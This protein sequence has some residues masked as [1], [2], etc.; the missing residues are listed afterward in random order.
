MTTGDGPVLF[1]LC[2]LQSA[3]HRHRGIARYATEQA[4]AVA[5]LFPGRLGACL[6]NPDLT[7][8][9]RLDDLLATLP[10]HTSEG[11]DWA[12]AGLL[13]IASP[14]EMS[15]PLHRLLPPAAR[16]AK[17]PWVVTFYDLIPLLMPEY[18]LEDP[19][20]R[21]RYRARVQLVRAADAVLTLSEAT[22]RD[23]VEHLGLDPERVTV[24]G[25]GTGPE[26]VPPAS[27]PAAAATAAAAVPGLRPP[28]VFYTGS[29][30]KRKNLERL[31][32]A[33]AS[34]PPG[35]RQAHQLVVTCALG[36]LQRNH[37]LWLAGKAG[38]GDDLLLTGFVPDDVLLRLYQ[39]TELFIFPSLYEGYGLP[40]AEALACG[41]PVLAAG[42]SSMPEIVGPESLF[43]PED[44][45]SMATAI[46]RGLTDGGLRDR[47]LGAAGKPP[48][49]WADV[50]T[51]TVEVYDSVLTGR[52]TTGRPRPLRPRVEPRAGPPRRRIAVATAATGVTAERDVALAAD[53]AAHAEVHLFLDPALSPGLRLAAH[54]GRLPERVDGVP[55]GVRV[56]PVA[57]LRVVEALAGPFDEVVYCL[58]DDENHTGCLAALFRRPG[59]VLAHDVRF[60]RLYT[61]AAAGGALPQDLHRTLATMYGEAVPPRLGADGTMTHDDAVR[62]GAL[63]VGEVLAASTRFVTTSARDADVVRLATPAAEHH[64]L[65]VLPAETGGILRSFLSDG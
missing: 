53:L 61:A 50:A 62:A 48:S 11:V 10:V 17:I 4:L 31:L 30:E 40:V 16:A 60:P 63:M 7:V 64:K 29:Y 27:R 57:N 44:T 43:D 15:V 2:A 52:G 18:Y 55:D 25:A 33:W 21:R 14:F 36:P 38:L 47:L 34:L 5:R 51:R 41:A 1:D 59:V 12:T 8:P 24:V 39:G 58:A 3:E 20:L 49:T 9:E 13:H 45:V 32:E 37:L 54:P 26:F 46:E 65:A 23:A 35:L 6:L 56:H 28:Y 22:R 42:S 19:G